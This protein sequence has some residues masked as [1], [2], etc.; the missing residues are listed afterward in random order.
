MWRSTEPAMGKPP[1]QRI[2]ENKHVSA[3]LDLDLLHLPPTEEEGGVAR[4]MS[5]SQ[6]EVPQ[7]SGVVQ[8]TV[9]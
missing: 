3:A 1:T 5:A 6:A 9:I 4:R 2:P 8:G 7:A